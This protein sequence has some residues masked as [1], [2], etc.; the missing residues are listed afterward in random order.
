MN[1]IQVYIWG[2]RYGFTEG[3]ALFPERNRLTDASEIQHHDAICK[4]FTSAK[5]VAFRSGQRDFYFILQ[6]S[7]YRI[8]SLVDKSHQDI[9]GRE[10]YLVYSI[11]CPKTNFIG[12]NIKDGLQ[13]LKKL[14]K[15][16]N[17]DY[18]IRTN[19]FTNDQVR[20]AISNLSL[21]SGNARILGSNA[22]YYFQNE[23]ELN[24]ND[25]TGHEV[26]FMQTGSNPELASHL[27]LSVQ[28]FS[29]GQV[30]QEIQQNSRSVG[31]FKSFLSTKTNFQKANELFGS[32]SS[33]LTINERTEFENWKAIE[34]SKVAIVQL[35]KLIADFVQNNASDY[36]T[37]AR[38]IEQFPKIT[39]QLTGAE[40]KNLE[41][42]KNNIHSQEISSKK[43]EIAEIEGLI[44]RAA[45]LEYNNSI[46]PIESRLNPQIEAKL[47]ALS[48]KKLQKWR[49]HHTLG[50]I[51]FEINQ[52]H[53][54]IENGSR[55]KILAK[56]NEWL[57]T[58]EGWPKRLNGASPFDKKMQEKYQYL[59]SK[60]WVKN[61]KP[62]AKI[63]VMAFVAIALTGGGFFAAK[64]WSAWFPPVVDVPK[65]P[66]PTPTPPTPK[67]GPGGV[68]E[69]VNPANGEQYTNFEYKGKTY[70]VEKSLL[71]DAGSKYGDGEKFG[72]GCTYRYSEDKN[73]WEM[74]K[75]DFDKTWTEAKSTDIPIILKNWDAKFKSE[76]NTNKGDSNTNNSDN[77]N[78]NNGG[79][80]NNNNGGNANNNNGGN[81]NNNN[82]GN[83]NNKDGGKIN[84]N[85]GGEEDNDKPTEEID[86]P[87]YIDAIKKAVKSKN[88]GKECIENDKKLSRK[89]KDRL[90]KI[91]PN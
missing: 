22:I 69:V 51:Q 13:N 89:V 52:I 43:N 20:S 38:I 35:Q 67:P 1:A 36:A 12:G 49:E 84:N 79:N 27:N 72:N 56:Q 6:D 85:N 66:T 45:E 41:A 46:K 3:T 15:T 62:I 76:Q 55:A 87:I 86:D 65:D 9:A 30:N 53:S 57:K 75:S 59:V 58:I 29:V 78:N 50:E 19:M 31:E 64:N 44:D 70:R 5:D 61:D 26:Y 73:K 17:A 74:K 60:Q 21:T 63:A 18:T 42:W 2:V 82:G 7:S 25:Y 4:Y 23:S 32:I 11:V 34:T 88:C 54:D 91:I 24:L 40:Q 37:C 33:Q 77:A 14:Y 81:T 10:T 47:S 83:A 48:A 90:I 39:N 80:T 8:Y 16:R 71:T 68:N 28:Q